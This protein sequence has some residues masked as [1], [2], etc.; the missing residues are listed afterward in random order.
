MNL[1]RGFV[2]LKAAR[3][4]LDIFLR[5]LPFQWPY[6]ASQDLSQDSIV[7]LASLIAVSDI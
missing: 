7:V 3:N 6:L 5:H 4:I 1:Y 2:G